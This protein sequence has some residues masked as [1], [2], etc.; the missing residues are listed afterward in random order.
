VP[1]AVVVVRR[2]AEQEADRFAILPGGEQQQSSGGIGRISG[3]ARHAM[4]HQP[5][6][7]TGPRVV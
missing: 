1:G 4:H 5:E 3:C 2:R 6:L 7:T